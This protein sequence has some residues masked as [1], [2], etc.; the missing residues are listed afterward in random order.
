MTE[1]PLV[2]DLDGTLLR[3]DLLMETGLVYLRD[4]PHRFLDPVLW[5]LRGRA[6]L[7]QELAHAT[8][9]DVSVL[10]YDEAVIEFIQAER[11]RGRRVVLATASHRRLADRVAEHLALF[12]E[13]IATEAGRNL[14]AAA[15][16]DALV[17]TFGEKGFDYIG[18]SVDDV[19]V[20]G[21]A[22]SSF[23]A[24]GSPAV[25]SR[26]RSI[27]NLSGIVS[28]AR[29]SWRD[30]ARALR[31]HQWLKNLLIFVPLLAAHRYTEWPLVLDALLAFLCFG[32]CASSVYILNDLLDLRDDRHHARKRLRP[33]ASGRL[34]I[35]SGLA[36]FPLLL[37]LAFILAAWR[38]PP[39]FL[40]GLAAY[41]V[42]TL[43]YSL[44]LKRRTV[45]DVLALAALYT[46]R[47]IVGALAI[48]VPLSFWLLAFSMFIF[49]SLALVKRYAELFQLRAQGKVDQVRGRGYFADDLGMIASLGAAAGYIA[50]L[51][52]ALY[53]ND[54]N[55]RELY[56]HQEVIWLACPLL[57][58]WVSR[59]WMLAH[60]GLMNEDPVV[61]AVQDRASLLIGALVAIVF[62]AAT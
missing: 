22:R 40:G 39:A 48:S 27:G 17:Q 45:V 15:K 19:P 12:D 37:G 35:L 57:L 55:T 44:W 56:R 38:L 29:S 4:R 5:L 34:P 32:L 52:L 30:W 21:A 20:W 36:A 18:N 47:I 8:D 9:L 2:V 59:V 51:V 7:K 46:L 23:V 61:F 60:R 10:P 42:L 33:F 43:A 58:A 24:N 1:L 31:L 49:L 14:S 13:V 16:R 26:A 28:K 25:E 3:S 54:P 50:V 11:G 62:W 6:A 53:I 41:Y